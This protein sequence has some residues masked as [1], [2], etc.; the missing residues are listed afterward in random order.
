VRRGEVFWFEPDP[1]R[2][3]EQAGRRPALLVS[4]DSINSASPVVVVVPLTTWRGQRLYP[5]DTLIRRGEGGLQ[6]D[7][8]ALA[9]HVRA[10]DRQR[11]RGRL[12]EVAQATLGQ[13]EEALLQ[14]LDIPR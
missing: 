12:G 5:S 4:R 7:S 3:S 10:I 11:L 8:V 13:V 1:V 14:V 6:V 2:G 9:L